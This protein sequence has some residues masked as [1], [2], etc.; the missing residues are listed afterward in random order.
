LI[1]IE[2]NRWRG[3]TGHPA[4]IQTIRRKIRGGI[5]SQ[6][7]VLI[8]FE[9]TGVT[10]KE[11]IEIMTGWDPATAKGCGSIHTLPYPLP[12]DVRIGRVTGG[13]EV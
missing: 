4:V 12:A 13:G 2:L 9:R 5:E 6:R 3:K 1:R 11:V 8:D 7:T 10:K